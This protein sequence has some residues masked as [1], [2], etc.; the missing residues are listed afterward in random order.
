LANK[1]VDP[2]ASF[3]VNLSADTSSLE[4][5][6]ARLKEQIAELQLENEQLKEAIEEE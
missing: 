6:N 3:G 5:E 1:I 2:E 4:A